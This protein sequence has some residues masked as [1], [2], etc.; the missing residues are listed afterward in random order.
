MLRAVELDR[1]PEDFLQDEPEGAAF[2]KAFQAAGIRDFDCRY[3]AIFRADQRIATVPFFLGSYNFGTLLPDGLLKKS[4]SW[5]S[6]DYACAGH[7]STDFGQ[8]DGEISAEII[9]LIVDI[10]SKKAPLVA[11]KGYSDDLPTEGFVRARGLPVAILNVSGDYYSQLDSHRRNDFRHKLKV[12]SA[13]R[14]EE[15]ETLPESL[16]QPV[17]HLYLDT[18]QHADIRFEVLTPEYFSAMAGL[19]KFHLY[20]EEDRLIG[21]LQTLT[22][23]K[24]ASLKYMGMDH[25]RNRQYYLYFAMCLKGIESAIAAGCSRIELG[26]SSYPAKH[27]M[28]C[29]LV[30]TFIYFRHNN[31][32]L[33]ALLAKCKFL[34]EP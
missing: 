17:Y 11:W 1:P 3:L 23:G 9:G 10:L 32:L 29:E 21:F 12:A 14:F 19:G 27:L 26:V 28:G 13:L 7:P 2:H 30:E 33:H 18:L 16:L 15:H 8:I 34:I 22:R 4:L 25:L 24:R 6:F 5:I 20:F 31:P